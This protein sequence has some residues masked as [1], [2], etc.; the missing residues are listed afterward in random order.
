MKQLFPTLPEQI[1]RLAV[2]IAVLLGGL[3]VLRQFVIP[4]RLRE[5]GFHRESAVRREA[6]RDV[7]FAGAPVCG[8]CHDD[9]MAAKAE[10]HHRNLSCETCHGPAAAHTEDPT[11]VAPPDIPR[12]REECALCHTYDPSRPTG[13]PQINPVVHNPLKPC[14]TC[15]DPHSPEPPVPPRECTACHGEIARTKAISHHALLECTTCHEASGEHRT[16]PRTIKPSKPSSRAFCGRCHGSEA[17]GSEAPRIDLATHEPKYVC[18][19]C[20]YP[21]MPEGGRE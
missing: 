9:V 1:T 21:H 17:E 4:P 13:F 14:M 10:G 18:W 2:V 3:I 6:E 7:R 11:E 20:H 15:H 16:S 19:Q 8:E 12:S 5:T